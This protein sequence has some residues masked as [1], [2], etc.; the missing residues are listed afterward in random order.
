MKVC[1]CWLRRN[2]ISSR[3]AR[4]KPCGIDGFQRTHNILLH[5]VLVRKKDFADDRV[6]PGPEIV[7]QEPETALVTEMGHSQRANV[8]ATE[9][10]LEGTMQKIT[11]NAL[12]GGEDSFQT[13]PVEFN[14]Q[15]VDGRTN[16]RISAYT[17]TRLT[18]SYW[19]HAA[20]Q[21][22]SSSCKMGAST[23]TRQQLPRSWFS[24]SR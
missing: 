2:H 24:T 22:E 18:G 7:D 6:N 16:V 4:S 17:A 15:G 12:D 11:V 5:G 23:V 8:P 21:L 14:L 20:S 10:G 1:F 3:C 19:K 9:L 13:M